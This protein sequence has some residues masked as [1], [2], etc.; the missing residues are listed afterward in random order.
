MGGK[1]KP[2]LLARGVFFAAVFVVPRYA[3]AQQISASVETHS[4]FQH[5]FQSVTGAGSVVLTS[6]S[7]DSGRAHTVAIAQTEYGHNG[8]YA[9]AQDNIPMPAEG[10]PTPGVVP[11][12][13]E[14]YSAWSDWVTPGLGPNFDHATITVALFLSRDLG[15]GRKDEAEEASAS[16][17]WNIFAGTSYYGLGI[18]TSTA[19]SAMSEGGF[20]FNSDPYDLGTHQGSFERSPR[21]RDRRRLIQE[22]QDQAE[23]NTT[24]HPTSAAQRLPL[25]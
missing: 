7:S 13:A 5:D 23:N 9:L 12:G 11:V 8:V 14:G 3:A 16:L 24:C 20:G 10:D 15:G 21:S 19:G 22:D 2:I 4:V 6:T 18:E 1:F 25:R 17:D